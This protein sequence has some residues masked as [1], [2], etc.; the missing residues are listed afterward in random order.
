LASV[1]EQ[2]NDYQQQVALLNGLKRQLETDLHALHV[3]ID[4]NIENSKIGG[5]I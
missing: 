4:E 3:S 2:I 1:R 5:K